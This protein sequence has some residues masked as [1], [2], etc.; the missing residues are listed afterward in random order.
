MTIEERLARREQED[1]IEIGEI[2]ERFYNSEAGTIF[3][4]MLNGRIKQQI[5]MPEEIKTPADRRLGRAEGLQMIQDDIEFAID[6]MNR[7]KQPL[8]QGDENG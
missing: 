6:A 3:L 2:L 7:L 4:A 1:I 5:S 8:S